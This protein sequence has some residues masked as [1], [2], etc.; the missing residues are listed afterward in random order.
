[1]L[2]GGSSFMPEKPGC[3]KDGVNITAENGNMM[4]VRKSWRRQ[5]NS[6]PTER[7]SWKKADLLLMNNR[8]RLKRESFRLRM[9]SQ[10]LRHRLQ[11]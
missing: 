11:N 7:K 2:P 4:Q 3:Q 8:D 1:M 9:E 6:L 5:K 10:Q